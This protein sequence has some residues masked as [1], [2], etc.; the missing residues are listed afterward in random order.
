MLS[1]TNP[2]EKCLRRCNCRNPNTRQLFYNTPPFTPQTDSSMGPLAHTVNASS[3]SGSME[4]AVIDALSSQS[5][6][7][8]TTTPDSIPKPKHPHHPHPTQ[9]PGHRQPQ[10]TDNAQSPTTTPGTTP[11]GTIQDLP[12]PDTPMDTDSLQEPPESTRT[13]IRVTAPTLHSLLDI[14]V[15]NTP[16]HANNLPQ[17]HPKKYY[18]LTVFLTSGTLHHHSLTTQTTNNGTIS[19]KIYTSYCPQISYGLSPFP[20][21]HGTSHHWLHPSRYTEDP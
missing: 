9:T 10:N 19:M 17:S 18:P 1:L 4:Q 2:T 8:L 7:L 20:Y 16:L 3:T 14:D 11:D 13:P 12:S 21:Y 15:H 6:Y 5:P